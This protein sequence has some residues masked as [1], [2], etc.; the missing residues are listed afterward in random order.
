MIEAVIF[1]F[2]GTL[3]ELSLDFV[4]MRKEIEKI[5][6]AY[7]D[8]VVIKRLGGLYLL[9]MISETGRA[10]G[11][12]GE[13]FV[14][15][16]S[17]RLRDLE[18]AAAR[19]KKVYPYTRGVLRALRGKGAKIG[20]ITRNCMAAV[21]TVFP[22]MEAHVDAVITREH[23]HEVKPKPGHVEAVLRALDATPSRA[24]LVGDHPT[25]IEAGKGAGAATVGV[26]SG[27]T[28]REE[29]ERAGAAYILDDIRGVVGLVEGTSRVP[30]RT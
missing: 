28:G 5:A 22:D 8:A 30:V 25:D 21:E 18:V 1:D 9:E 27:R 29:F 20:I 7:V 14:E 12:R 16:A 13:A 15:E 24:L 6:E 10:A 3:T 17:A 2:D 4:G 11:D 26:L 19:G 23:V